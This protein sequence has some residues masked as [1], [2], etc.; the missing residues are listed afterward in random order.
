[1]SAKNKEEET[2]EGK[3]LSYFEQ[4]MKLLGVTAE[5]NRIKVWRTVEGKNTLVDVPVFEESEKGIKIYV[6]T[7]NRLRVPFAREG[8]RWKKDDYHITR[9]KEPKVKPNGDTMKYDIP[10]GQGTYPFIPDQLIEKFEK[11]EHIDTLIATEGF[12]KAWKGA[13]CGLDIIGFSSITHMRDKETGALY[14]DITSILKT[15]TVRRF[16]WLTDGDCRNITSKEVIDGTD[17]YRRPKGFF[18]SAYT[19]QQLLSNFTDLEKWFAHVISDSFP[20]NPKG[21][22]DLLISAA[23]SYKFVVAD[24]LSWNKS[25]TYF[26]KIN[27]SFTTASLHRYFFLDN[28]NTFYVHHLQ[29]RPDI[30]DK[31]FVWNGTRYKWDEEKSECKIMVPGAA[32]DYFRVGDNYYEF[33]KIVNKYE[34]LELQFHRRMKSTI[35]DDHGKEFV[36]HVARYKAFCNVPNHL[37]YQQVIHNNFNM[38]SRF[39]HEPAEDECVMEDFPSIAKFMLHIFGSGTI[40]YTDPETKKKYEYKEV[41]LGYDYLQILYQKPYRMLP[42]LC[43][44]SKE[45]ETGK[46]TFGKFLKMLFTANA[47]VVG[48]AELADNFNAA[49]AGK[50]LIICDETKIDKQNVVEK[51]KSLST[52][53]K[54]FMNAKGRDHV[55]IDFFGK[56]MF[57]SNNEEN[58]IYANENDRRYWVRKVPV[59]KELNNNLLTDMKEEIPAFLSWLNKRQMVTENKARMW[60][61]PVLL[62]TEALKRVIA[63]SAPTIEKDLRQFIREKFFDFGIEELMMTRQALHKECFNNK[64]EA[65]YLEKILKESLKVD[66]YHEYDYDGKSFPSLEA[67]QEY[68]AATYQNAELATLQ[69]VKQYKLKRFS[70][71]R[72]MELHGQDGGATKSRVE[73]KDVGRPY[74]FKREKFLTP[75]EIKSIKLDPEHSFINKVNKESPP[76]HQLELGET[77]SSPD[78]LPF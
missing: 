31:E 59:I 73:N 62:K 27:I 1:M 6:V 40:N 52:A 76:P 30:K 3:E 68:A 67:A 20:D 77:S 4:R 61:D 66:L 57:I 17:L 14:D 25:N 78:D 29:S 63:Y 42:I 16:I 15:C 36:K 50:L 23:A 38:Y 49:W 21:L 56:F 54:V 70:Y 28:V 41:D 2:P 22:D 9:L 43:L 48:N 47:A 75:D 39:E 55:E 53:D 46:S 35:I 64:Y 58:F 60:F 18:Q 34:D 37:N 74:V 72:W 45:N 5:N 12:F 33:V 71:P 51:V 7:I 65:N 13:Q 19:F 69:A 32:K 11:K 44:V 8:S 26:H 24:L 10:K